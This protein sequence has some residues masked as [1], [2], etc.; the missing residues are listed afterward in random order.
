MCEAFRLRAYITI[1]SGVCMQLCN[2]TITPETAAALGVTS[3]GTTFVY[4]ELVTTLVNEVKDAGPH[5]ATWKGLNERGSQV[6]SGVYFYRLKTKDFIQ[7]NK[8]VILK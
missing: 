5:T 1:I 3:N 7:T 2:L 8:M 4:C 6:A